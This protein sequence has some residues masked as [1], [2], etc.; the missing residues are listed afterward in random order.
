MNFGW[1]LTWIQPDPWLSR[2]RE[3]L[4]PSEGVG[5]PCNVSLV[6]ATVDAKFGHFCLVPNIIKEQNTMGPFESV[7]NRLSYFWED[8]INSQQFGWLDVLQA[9]R[10]APLVWISE[11]LQ[12][13]FQKNQLKITIPKTFFVLN[14]KNNC[15]SIS[16]PVLNVK[17]QLF[18]W[19]KHQF[20]PC[21]FATQWTIRMWKCHEI[22]ASQGRWRLHYFWVPWSAPSTNTTGWSKDQTQAI[23]FVGLLY[24]TH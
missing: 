6:E 7:S 17:N 21:F 3:V 20:C 12:F 5:M 13:G 19:S 10:C 9:G 14:V 23:P 16:K 4:T 8:E 1:S 11:L 24:F 15:F 18:W 2:R 22:L